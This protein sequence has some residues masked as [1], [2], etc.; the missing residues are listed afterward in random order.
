MQP[1]ARNACTNNDR[2]YR[3]IRRELTVLQPPRT[4]TID[5]A[6]DNAQVW[7][8]AIAGQLDCR[9][10]RIAYHAL[11]TVLH[12]L[13]DRLP[14][15]EAV[16]LGAQLPLLIRGIYYEGWS[17]HATPPR[18]RHIEEFLGLI[19]RSMAAANAKIEPQ[20]VVDAVFNQLLAHLS[21]TDVERVV[22]AMPPGMRLLFNT[23]ARGSGWQSAQS[24]ALGVA[25]T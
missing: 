16:T 21:P 4:D 18:A 23:T 12:V 2:D 19:E 3:G 20:Q 24:P 6:F 11:R 1:G 7:L 14:L 9:D 13:R 10:V 17:P 22:P 25:Y 5:Y 8:R 15:P